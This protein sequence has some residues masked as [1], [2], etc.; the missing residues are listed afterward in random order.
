MAEVRVLVTTSTNAP[1]AND[2][3][4]LTGDIQDSGT[5]TA[6]TDGSGIATFTTIKVT[7]TPKTGASLTATES[8]GGQSVSAALRHHRRH[9][10]VRAAA[11]HDE[12]QRRH[13]ARREREGH[14]TAVNGD[15]GRPGDD[16]DRHEPGRRRARPG[17]VRRREHRRERR[18]DVHRRSASARTSRSPAP[19]YTLLGVDRQRRAST[20]TPFAI[21]NE[22]ASQCDERVHGDVPVRQHRD[23][24]L[25]GHADHRERQPRLLLV[26]LDGHRRDRHGDPGRRPGRAAHVRG[27]ARERHHPRPGRG[28][29][30]PGLQEQRRP[31]RDH[32]RLRDLGRPLLA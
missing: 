6:T 31:G 22:V 14:A 10:R 8:A 16:L 12:V 30:V 26:D 7:Q 29:D 18:R 23:H 20:A 5:V 25:G 15:R 32:A 13:L 9:D 11:D 17:R 19:G 27:P 21:A 24:R 28:R 2:L 4:T 3:V 1:I